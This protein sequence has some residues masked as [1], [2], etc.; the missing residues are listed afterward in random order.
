MRPEEVVKANTADAFDTFYAA[1][2]YIVRDYLVR[3]RLAFYD[4]VAEYCT[5]EIPVPQPCSVVDVGCGTGHMLL[6]LRNRLGT[7][8]LALT[9][10][11][12]SANAMLWCRPLLPGATFV[13]GDLYDAQLP[14]GA[15]DLVLCIETLE[16]V[17]DPRAALCE[18]LRV[19]RTGGRLVL[20]VPN[21]ARDSWNGHRHFWTPEQFTE[22][23]GPHGLTHLR[24]LQGDTVLLAEVVG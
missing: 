15:Y 20:T 22:F 2:D 4:L 7:H 13:V 21:G 1:D 8:D 12:F 14:A 17:L 3:E 10:L 18:L 5:T 16:H 19:C 23:L 6:A 24:Q 9:G 11:D